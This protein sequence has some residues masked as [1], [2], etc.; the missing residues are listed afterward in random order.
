[1]Q[2]QRAQVPNRWRRRVRESAYHNAIFLYG[3]ALLA[4]IFIALWMIER[5]R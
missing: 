4:I 5:L 3:L 1:M 2:L